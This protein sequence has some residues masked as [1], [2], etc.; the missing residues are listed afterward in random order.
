MSPGME[1]SNDQLVEA[2]SAHQRRDWSTS[3]AAFVRI[4]GV[5]S[6]TL[7]DLD[8]YASAA[9]RVGHAREA[10]RLAERVYARLARTDPIA[11]ARKAAELG[12]QWRTRGHDTVA[13]GWVE[14]A[15]VLLVGAP[16]GGA[17]GY[18]AYLDAV[19]AL[20]AADLAALAR[21]AAVLRDTAVETGDAALSVLE[22]VVTGVYAL[23]DARPAEGYRLLDDALIPVMDERLPIEWAGDA[24]RVVLGSGPRWADDQHVAAWTQSLARW[25][26]LTGVASELITDLP[27]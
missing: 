12:L 21:S 11:A 26:E 18:V 5:R 14:Q 8:A 15:R 3:Y 2:R 1:L 10:V 7:D 25:C 19:T 20:S 16:T 24:Y 27:R 9:W 22:R 23:L 13:R 6:M 4:D 17:H